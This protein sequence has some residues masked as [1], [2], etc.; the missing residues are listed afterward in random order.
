MP[1]TFKADQTPVRE[2]IYGIIK[3]YEDEDIPLVIHVSEKQN[4]IIVLT[5]PV[6]E[7]R[8]MEIYQFN[9]KK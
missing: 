2:A 6:A 9:K 7:S 3:K 5:K 4:K 1:Q 8:K